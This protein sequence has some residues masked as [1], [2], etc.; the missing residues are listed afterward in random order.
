MFKN[1][2]LRGRI[3]RR[4]I[5]ALKEGWR[6]LHSEEFHDLHWPDIISIVESVG[7]R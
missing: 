2:L 7:M 6:K 5:E 1:S 4:K 3:L